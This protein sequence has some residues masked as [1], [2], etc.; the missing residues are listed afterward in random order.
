MLLKYKG[1]GRGVS[2]VTGNYYEA[3]QIHDEM[4]DGYA[5]FDEGEDWYGYGV[6][7]VAENFEIVAEDEQ[8]LSRAV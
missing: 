5:I 4:G 3:R 2:F 6:R 1:N 7:F 8:E